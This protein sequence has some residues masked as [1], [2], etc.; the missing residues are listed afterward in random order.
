MTREQQHTEEMFYVQDYIDGQLTAIDSDM[1]KEKNPLYIKDNELKIMCLWWLLHEI[2]NSG[3]IE[4]SLSQ[5]ELLTDSLKNN[6]KI[7]HYGFFDR[8]D[9]NLK[10]MPYTKLL[11]ED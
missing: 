8:H 5:F 11:K 3:S 7:M 1:K 2:E 10:I 4:R 9:C 6:I